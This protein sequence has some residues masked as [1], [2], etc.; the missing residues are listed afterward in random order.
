MIKKDPKLN[1]VRSLINTL[2]ISSCPKET[3]KVS[4][5]Y[6]NLLE[7]KVFFSIYAR[8]TKRAYVS[9]LRYATKVVNDSLKKKDFKELKE[10]AKKWI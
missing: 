2:L 10:A 1:E 3:K 6:L 4:S 5:S 8:E 7:K 9:K